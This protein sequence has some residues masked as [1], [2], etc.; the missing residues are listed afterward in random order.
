MGG[1]FSRLF[2]GVRGLEHLEV[3]RVTVIMM[4][5]T[6]NGSR[7]HCPIPLASPPREVTLALQ[8]DRTG[9]A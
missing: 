5:A 3:A 9:E 4:I 1:G 6:I 7:T 2:D 8:R